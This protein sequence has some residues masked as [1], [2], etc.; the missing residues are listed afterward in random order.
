MMWDVHCHF[1]S[2]WHD[3][4]S[5][6]SLVVLN[7]YFIVYQ[8]LSTAVARENDYRQIE[9]VNVCLILW[10]KVGRFFSFATTQ[11]N[12]FEEHLTNR[13][14]NTQWSR[15]RCFL[16]QSKFVVLKVVIDFEEGSK[17]KIGERLTQLQQSQ[18]EVYWKIK[19][20]GLLCV[21]IT[22]LSLAV[23]SHLKHKH[24]WMCGVK[25]KRVRTREMNNGGKNVLEIKPS[26]PIKR[27][28]RCG[29]WSS[30]NER[31]FMLW[32]GTQ[33]HT[34]CRIGTHTSIINTVGNFEKTKWNKR[35][36]RTHRVVWINV[37]VDECFERYWRV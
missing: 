29:F 10:A 37:R 3:G 32:E 1:I 28:A 27:S 9:R 15:L 34:I 13:I 7:Y 4:C 18:Y 20:Q 25:N 35:E 36:K 5:K 30:R 6:K 26:G 23:K 14:S 19:R 21:P 2:R 33:P 22:S 17:L 12:S 11:T 8:T 16:Y 31:V 24:E